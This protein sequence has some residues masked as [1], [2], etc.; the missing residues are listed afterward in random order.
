[1]AKNPSWEEKARAYVKNLFLQK[2]SPHYVFHNYSQVENMVEIC[3]DFAEQADLSKKER[4]NLLVATW[5]AQTGLTENMGPAWE[6]S[7]LILKA[8][9]EAEEMEETRREDILDIIEGAF[10]NPEPQSL[11]QKILY[12]AYW[13]FPGTQKARSI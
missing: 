8:F 7:R 1:M 2:L 9:L 10:E 12:D 11:P 13:V 5:F 6:D 4:Q 3:N